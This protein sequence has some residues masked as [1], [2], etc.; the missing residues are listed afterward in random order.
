MDELV[1]QVAHLVLFGGCSDVTVTVEVAL[2]HAINASH[3][4]EAPDVELASLVQKR[5]VD[6]L[7][8]DHGA[9]RGCVR[10]NEAL[11]LGL[12]RLDLDADAPI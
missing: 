10:V 12:V 11:D 5:V 9:V 6:V 2:D 7:L 4:R 3:E 1:L 8:Q